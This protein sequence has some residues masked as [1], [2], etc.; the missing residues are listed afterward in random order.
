MRLVRESLGVLLVLLALAV[1]FWS[2][3]E[4]RGHDYVS[5][6]VLVMVGLGVLGAGL[7]MVRPTMGE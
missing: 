2:V 7:E 6:I 1:L 5:A 4:L 3:V